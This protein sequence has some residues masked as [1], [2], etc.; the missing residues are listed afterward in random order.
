MKL[1]VF[2][3]SIFFIFLSSDNKEFNKRDLNE[4]NVNLNRL[5]AI[6]EHPERNTYKN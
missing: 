2:L 3:V 6:Y 5:K 1:I 4:L